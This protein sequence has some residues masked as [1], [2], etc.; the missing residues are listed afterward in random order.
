MSREIT[1][2]LEISDQVFATKDRYRVKT[3]VHMLMNNRLCRYHV[4]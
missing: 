1:E 3:L 4:I 2:D